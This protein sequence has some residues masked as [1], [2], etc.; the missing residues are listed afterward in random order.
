[1]ANCDETF[2]AERAFDELCKYG[3]FDYLTNYS[4]AIQ[5]AL[6][7]KKKIGH[8]QAEELL[9]LLNLSVQDKKKLL[10]TKYLPE[11]VRARLGDTT[12][13]NKLMSEYLS[14]NTKKLFYVRKRLVDE[15]G[16]VATPRTIRFLVR[17][18]NDTI[19]G[20][21]CGKAS[22]AAC[23]IPKLGRLNPDNQLLT[24]QYEKVIHYPQRSS[25]QES[26]A[27]LK[28]VIDWM[29]KTYSVAPE[30]A[31]PLP[32]VAITGICEH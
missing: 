7:G 1:L 15:M 5:A 13:E 20:S 16:T 2:P 23:I 28:K 21:D 27:Y 25:P 24:D 30:I 19:Y 3:R 11:Y 17:V 12:A 14:A 31:E 6:A 32:F 8:K 10:D 22:I 9:C 29:K 4:D 26:T 18:F